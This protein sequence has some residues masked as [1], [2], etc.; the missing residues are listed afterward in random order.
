MTKL[1]QPHYHNGETWEDANDWTSKT[2]YLTEQDA[3]SE[4]LSNGLA[5]L[6]ETLVFSNRKIYTVDNTGREYGHRV[7]RY[8]YV[9]ELILG[10]DTDGVE[11]LRK[12]GK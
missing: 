10:G 8:A 6:G 9:D 3:V 12:A 7:Y 11:I 2:V 5:D 4:I 1:Y